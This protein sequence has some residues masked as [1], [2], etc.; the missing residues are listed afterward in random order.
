MSLL[1]SLLRK[2]RSATTAIPHN[3]YKPEYSTS[4]KKTSLVLLIL[5]NAAKNR[6]YE[7]ATMY[8]IPVCTD[9]EVLL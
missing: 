9:Y 7:N 4:K 2:R 5:P 6:E 3:Q 8:C 1:S